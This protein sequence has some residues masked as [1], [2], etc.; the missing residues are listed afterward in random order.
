M[1]SK[2]KDD[3]EW[4]ITKSSN[5]FQNFRVKN[6]NYRFYRLLYRVYYLQDGLYKSWLMLIL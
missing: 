5:Y 4:S 1:I 6:F 2:E 3:G